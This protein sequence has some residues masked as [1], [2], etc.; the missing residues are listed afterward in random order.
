MN[1]EATDAALSEAGFGSLPDAAA[2]MDA[3]RPLAEQFDAAGHSLYLVGG[4]V[5]D[6]LLGRHDAGEDIDLTTDALPAVS[7]GLMGPVSSA[8]WTQGERFGTIGAHIN[9]RAIEVTTHRAESYDP[10]SRKPVVA[11][12]DELVT[13]LSRRDFTINAMA[14]SV[15]DGSFHDPFGGRGDLARRRLTTPLDPSISFTDDPLRMMRAARFIPR[16][17]LDVAPEV[18]EA[19]TRLA[20][21]LSIVSAERLHDE[22]ERLLVLPKPKAGLDFLI[23]SG[24]L[25]SI[26]PEVD[27]EHGPEAVALAATA[28]GP[29]GEPVSAL[30]RRVLL[31]S[32]VGAAGAG[33]W[34]SHLRYSKAERLATV[35]LLESLALL[36]PVTADGRRAEAVPGDGTLRRIVARV[37]LALVPEL[38]LAADIALGRRGGGIE[39]LNELASTEDLSDLGSPV[40]GGE[41][42]DRLDLGPG[43]GVGRLVNRLAEHR[44]EHGPFGREAAFELAARWAAEEGAGG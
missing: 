24:L 33:E 30:V 26:A 39:R 41:L 37:G 8:L 2:I 35:R 14:V 17:D 16:F 25:S 15:I 18:F 42:I 31:L 32:G 44:L 21:R 22:L 12:G 20:P 36:A 38:S 9:G 29:G 6:L 28:V 19:V 5:R 3:V 13:D 23:T 10:E 11:F 27:H 7:K 43:P 4:V 34:L 1:P 40:S